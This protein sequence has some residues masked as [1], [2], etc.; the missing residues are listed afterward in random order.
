MVVDLKNYLERILVELGAATI[1]H[2]E[3]VSGFLLDNEW[4]GVSINLD[5]YT[6]S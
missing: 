1:K 5:D 6:I 3:K 2:R 4:F